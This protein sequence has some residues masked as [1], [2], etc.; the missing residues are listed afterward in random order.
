MLVPQGLAM[1]VRYGFYVQTYK[2]LIV[3]YPDILITF[4]FMTNQT[5]PD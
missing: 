3:N 2:K 5:E 4:C 1:A